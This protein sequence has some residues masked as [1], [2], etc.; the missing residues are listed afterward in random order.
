M[1]KMSRI[2][3]SVVEQIV[4]EAL[5]EGAK[6]MMMPALSCM[7]EVVRQELSFARYLDP[8]STGKHPPIT[9]WNRMKVRTWVE[10]DFPASL[11]TVPLGSLPCLGAGEAY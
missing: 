9:P 4:A 8:A 5:R 11:R 3:Q 7:D 2:E 6:V 10:Q 1:N